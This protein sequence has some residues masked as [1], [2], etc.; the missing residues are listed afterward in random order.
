MA[1]GKMYF[2]IFS[3]MG[4]VIFA[5]N[6]YLSFVRFDEFLI[7]SVCSV[8]SIPVIIAVISLCLG[9]VNLRNHQKYTSEENRWFDKGIKILYRYTILLVILFFMMILLMMLFNA[10]WGLFYM[11]ALWIG[12][13]LF[14]VGL[15]L[16]LHNYI[17]KSWRKYLSVSSILAVIY[18]GA[19]LF[20][21]FYDILWFRMFTIGSMDIKSLSFQETIIFFLVKLSINLSFILLALTIHF[22]FKKSKEM[23]SLQLFRKNTLERLNNLFFTGSFEEEGVVSK[24]INNIHEERSSCDTE[25]GTIEYD[26][27]LDTDK[28][29]RSSTSKGIKYLIMFFGLGSLLWLFNLVFINTEPLLYFPFSVGIFSGFVIVPLMI[30]FHVL[31]TTN[32]SEGKDEVSPHHDKFF[33]KGR[34]LVRVGVLI[35]VGIPF[36][37]FSFLMIFPSYISGF[38]F[39]YLIFL[40]PPISFSL[41]WIGW[42]MFTY[43]LHDRKGRFV[44]FLSAAIGVIQSSYMSF[45]YL[46]RDIHYGTEESLIF[47]PIGL[48]GFC[49]YGLAT[50]SLMRLYSIEFHEATVTDTTKSFISFI[51]TPWNSKQNEDEYISSGE[52]RVVETDVSEAT[53][54]EG[55]ESEGYRGL[56]SAMRYLMFFF[57]GGVFISNFWV[58]NDLLGGLCCFMIF[59]ICVLAVVFSVALYKLFDLKY[60]YSSKQHR[61]L[62]V[63]RNF[64]LAGILMGFIAPWLGWLLLEIRY[65]GMIEPIIFIGLMI[66]VLCLLFWIG[67]YLLVNMLASTP[68][69]GFLWV[70][71]FVMAAHSI[72]SGV[73]TS[74]AVLSGDAVEG[75]FFPTHFKIYSLIF[76]G[77]DIMINKPWYLIPN[78]L[79]TT[80]F[81]LMMILIF[82]SLRRIKK[83]MEK[84]SN[85]VDGGE[86]I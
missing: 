65:G 68:K 76:L 66:T 75:L 79:G 81:V 35:L 1:K 31:A 24:L 73:L 15:Y 36:V 16:M 9:I 82:S 52:Q 39:V 27:A 72:S 19:I 22:G 58:F 56:I 3:I 55:K 78:I 53:Y 6:L 83:G 62:I 71:L 29:S 11:I 21:L 12:Y 4:T 17:S 37:L 33:N 7:Y 70:L 47:Y 84:S 40:M 85:D 23:G 59:F 63:S 8:I 42:S 38:D 80:A 18:G 45:F 60:L 74:A 86:K 30:V 41:M 69:K 46:V 10:N 2:L 13:F 34:T 77:S 54:P 28:H 32:M 57:V 44:L 64:I 26:N 48:L 25:C 5:G 61:R 14:W 67:W 50:Y 43:N 51:N 20:V 49:A